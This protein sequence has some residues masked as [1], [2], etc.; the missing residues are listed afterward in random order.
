MSSSDLCSMVNILAKGYCE[1]KN[2][3]NSSCD[4]NQLFFQTD[5]YIN[6]R[7]ILFSLVNYEYKTYSNVTITRD[8]LAILRDFLLSYISKFTSNTINDVCIHY[9]SGCL[10]YSFVSYE[11][12]SIISDTS[13]K[14]KE[15]QNDI[16]V[17]YENNIFKIIESFFINL[18]T[19][20][21]INKIQN[22]YKFF[23]I[24]K[25]YAKY[26]NNSLMNYSN[27]EKYCLSISKILESQPE[28]N[29]QA[30]Y[31]PYEPF[32]PNEP[33]YPTNQEVNKAP[34]K[35]D[36]RYIP[37]IHNDMTVSNNLKNNSIENKLKS[38]LEATEMNEPNEPNQPHEPS[39]L[40]KP[41]DYFLLSKKIVNN[42]KDVNENDI[43]LAISKILEITT[44]QEVSFIP[45]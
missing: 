2:N 9:T 42:T 36:I 8:E 21:Q 41:F 10:I 17:N 43:R 20:Y 7:L 35:L 16:A 24:G 40:Y 39:E 12:S 44:S 32:E 27:L 13:L 26:N 38:L 37:N 19:N 25:N 28:N 18:P 14:I 33:Y 3:N 4:K 31:S 30:Q 45:D 29:E 6:K 11:R 22:L 15:I 34:K 1:L 5:F 23:K